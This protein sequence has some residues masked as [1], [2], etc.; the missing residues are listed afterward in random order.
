MVGVQNKRLLKGVTIL[1]QTVEWKQVAEELSLS[2]GRIEEVLFKAG[3]RA[4]DPERLV[5]DKFVEL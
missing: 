5:Q 1:Q 3:A 4:D 2:R